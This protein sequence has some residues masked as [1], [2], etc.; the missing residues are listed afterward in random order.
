MPPVFFVF[1]T[2]LL[3][4]RS[5]VSF[6]KNKKMKKLR[7]PFPAVKTSVFRILSYAIIFYFT[8]A[9]SFFLHLQSDLYTLASICPT[10]LLHLHRLFLLPPPSVTAFHLFSANPQQL[11]T[12]AVLARNWCYNIII[13][14]F[15]YVL[16]YSC[17]PARA[18]LNETMNTLMH[19]IHKLI[20]IITRIEPAQLA[21]LFCDVTIMLQV[22]CI[23]L[24]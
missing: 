20:I 23:D 16:I 2:S 21:M 10:V 4:T 7:G 1:F 9:L 14:V 22:Y 6:N 12:T 24:H 19:L 5:G 15:M 8:Y 18:P 3:S 13:I 11:T 17:P